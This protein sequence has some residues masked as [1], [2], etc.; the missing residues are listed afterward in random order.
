[1]PKKYVRVACYTLEGLQSKTY[2]SGNII[3]IILITILYTW[4]HD[5]FN[6]LANFSIYTEV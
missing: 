2:V 1:M 6:I 3:L 5:P 4:A